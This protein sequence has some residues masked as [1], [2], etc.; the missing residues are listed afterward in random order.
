[1]KIFITILS[2]F[3]VLTSDAQYR[4]NGICFRWSMLTSQSTTD[5]NNA[6]TVVVRNKYFENMDIGTNNGY[7]IEITGTGNLTFINC[8]FGPSISNGVTI[9]SFS[10]TAKFLG[11]VW[12]SN[13]VGIEF[14]A[15]SGNL[16]VDG[17]YVLNPWGAPQCKGQF[18]QFESVTTAD[19]YIKK[20]RGKSFWGE[21]NTEDWVSMY[22]STGTTLPI[23]IE[24]NYFEGGGP[25][26]SGGGIMSGDTDGGNQ[27]VQRNKLKNVGNYLFAIASGEDITVTNN[28][29]YQ[30]D[31]GTSTIACYVYGGQNGAT[32]CSGHEFSNNSFNFWD[33]GNLFYGGDG[34]P[35]EDC[36]DI[37]GVGSGYVADPNGAFLETNNNSLTLAAMK[38]PDNLFDIVSESQ[39][40]R[41][42]ERSTE[43]SDEGGCKNTDQR[44]RPTANAGTDQSISLSIATLTGNSGGTSQRWVCESG[45]SVPGIA[46]ATTTVAGL[47]NLTNGK[48]VF[49]YEKYDGNASD[50]DLVIV[51]VSGL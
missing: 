30:I 4:P 49:R 6:G 18:V 13:R 19:S 38:F 15:S 21:G 33:A 5:Y 7:D 22:A 10:G 1:M 8:V 47:S 34:S 12:I 36:G 2:F 25:S 46:G 20:V 29:A 43:F 11:C 28:Q 42:R 48:Y 26:T 23:R 17:G 27:V 50:S 24:D 39:L 45:P 44:A 37:I 14:S 51:N 41:L 3:I 40:W 9:T 35:T 16:Q 31:D 32:T